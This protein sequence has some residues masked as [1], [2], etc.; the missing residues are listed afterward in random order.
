MN[1]TQLCEGISNIIKG[2]AANRHG[3]YDAAHVNRWIQQF[4]EGERQLVLEETLNILKIS[5]SQKTNLQNLFLLSLNSIRSM[6]ETLVNFGKMHH[7]YRFSSTEI[8]NV[9]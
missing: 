4:D 3:T 1:Q 7:S 8:A 5:T 2:Y 9:S 6:E